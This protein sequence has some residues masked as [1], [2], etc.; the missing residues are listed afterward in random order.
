MVNNFYIIC[1][2]NFLS[3]LFDDI[4]TKIFL[5]NVEEGQIWYIK[6][7]AFEYGL[8]WVCFNVEKYF[9]FIYLF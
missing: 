8:T 5:T 4:Q 3:W 6:Q 1:M 9:Y 2:I 7:K